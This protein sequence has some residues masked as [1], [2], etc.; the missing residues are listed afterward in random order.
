[1]NLDVHCVTH[2]YLFSSFQERDRERK[3][4]EDLST[5]V[6]SKEEQLQELMR[7]QSEVSQLIKRNLAVVPNMEGSRFKHFCFEIL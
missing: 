3:I 2:V 4:K 1:M 5:Q 6:K 7:R